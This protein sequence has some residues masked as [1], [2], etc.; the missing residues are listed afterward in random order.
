MKV[1]LFDY[2]L[3][4]ERIAQRPLEDRTKSRLLV[5]DR[6]SGARTHSTF[7]E[8]AKHLPAR[9]V[10][11]LNETAVIPA[12]LLGKKASGGKVE[13]FL[14]HRLGATNDPYAAP[15]PGEPSWGRWAA[16][17]KPGKKLKDG[18]RV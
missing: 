11:V 14:L 6:K 5:L 3:P 15:A 12:R 17:V 8:I 2:E 16:L 7:A 13:I 10:L 1:D 9:C 18:T 4:E